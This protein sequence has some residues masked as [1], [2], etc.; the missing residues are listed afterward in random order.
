MPASADPLEQ[1]EPQK[2]GNN[3]AAAAYNKAAQEQR[4]GEAG[5]QSQ[6]LGKRLPVS[7]VDDGLQGAQV[8]H[9]RPD[10]DEL[11][12][13][14]PDAEVEEINRHV[15]ER[16]ADPG[17]RSRHELVALDDGGDRDTDDC[18]ETKQ[19]KPSGKYPRGQSTGDRRRAAPQADKAEV[20][21]ADLATPGRAGTVTG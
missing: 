1:P 17:A 16:V 20:E 15:G 7:V 8:G 11:E 5:S 4:R 21:V 2:I 3:G 19:G 13:P 14:L 9:L 10:A 6:K 18:L 12:Q